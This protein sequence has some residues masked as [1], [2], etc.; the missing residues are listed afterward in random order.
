MYKLSFNTKSLLDCDLKT[1]LSKIKEAGYEGAEI[2][3][4]RAG[5]NP[6][7]TTDAEIDDLKSFIDGLGLEITCLDTTD[8]C[9]LTDALNLPSLVS[10]GEGARE[11]RMKS[12]KASIDLAKKLGV[13]AVIVTSGPFHGKDP[14]YTTKPADFYKEA[15][16]DEDGSD[17]YLL[18]QLK[19]LAAYAGDTELW[20]EP[21]PRFYIRTI[22]RALEFINGVNS[23]NF[24]LL[25]SVPNIVK[26]EHNTMQT[27]AFT[28]DIMDKVANIH[29][30]DTRA[31][32][33][34]HKIPGEGTADLKGILA[35]IKNTGYDKYVCI[36]LARC[37]EKD[38]AKQ[39]NASLDYMKANA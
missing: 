4:T 21:T 6:Y 37:E 33:W 31:Q 7:T 29:F 32:I 26:G 28:K 11:A 36:D 39:L 2:Y 15:F 20:F 17:I 30:A 9:L 16:H 10:N 3:L 13:P 23:D 24:K 34:Y 19:E 5:L 25:L 12:Y 1:A 18:S 27:D 38:E 35:N 8:P 22:A 14:D